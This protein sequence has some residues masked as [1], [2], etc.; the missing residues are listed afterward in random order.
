MSYFFDGATVTGTN[1][2]DIFLMGGAV[3]DNIIHTG[4]GG[5]LVIAD[6]YTVGQ[7]ETGHDSIA[8]AST[9]FDTSTWHQGDNPMV[10]NGN[11]A[12]FAYYGAP[13]TAG[14]QD[15]FAITLSAGELAIFDIDG[16][17][18]NTVITL[19][20][21]AGVELAA[22]TNAP[23]ALGGLGSLVTSDSYLEFTAA[24]AGTY[25]LRVGEFGLNPT[26]EV[27]DE[28]L[29]FVSANMHVG[30][31][32]IASGDDIIYDDRGGD[33]IY[34]MGGDD[35]IFGDVAAFGGE[36]N[37]TFSVY[38]KPNTSDRFAGN[39]DGGNG[40]DTLDLTISDHTGKY[41]FDMNLNTYSTTTNNG[42]DMISI[43]IIHG[44]DVALNEF[45][46]NSAGNFFSAGSSFN[47]IDG[48][49]GIDTASYQFVS[50][51]VTID[52]NIT[53][54][55]HI[56]GPSNNRIVNFE[57]LEG[58]QFG[59]TITGD[60]GNNVLRGLGGDD[61]INGGAG[62]DIIAGGTGADDLD[63]GAGFD[64]LDFRGAA[65][66]VAFNIDTGGTVG[67]AAGDSYSNFEVIYG[68]SFNDSIT[69]SNANEFLY[70]E[71][72]NDT[73]NG[74]GGIDR[75]YGGEGNDVQRG[76]AGND[77]LYGSAGNDQ[78]NG[79]TGFDVANYTQATSAV[80]VNMVSGG[81]L[82]DAAGD[83]YF[84]IEAVYGSDFNDTLTGNNSVNELRGGDGDDSLNGAGGNDRLFGGEGA[85]MLDGGTGIDTVNFTTA[86]S[87]VHLDLATGGT[88]GE[89]AGDSYANIE[90]VFGS[91]FDDMIT[92]DDGNNRLEGRGGD[93]MLDGGL[94]NDRLQGGDGNDTIMGGEGVDTIFGQDGDDIMSGGAGNDF[95]FAGAGADSHDG[96]A[97][98]D[99]VSYVPSSSGVTVNMDTGGTGGDAAGDSYVS[100]ERIFGSGFDDS[101]TGSMGDDQLFGNGGNDYLAGG[102]GDDVLIGGAGS[103]SFGY[104]TSSDGADVISAFSTATEV[105]FI[106][107]GDPDYDSFAE[108]MAVATD[109]G[110]NVIFD[111]GGG[112]SLT[113][114]GQ[115][116]ANLS[117]D[118]FDFSGSPAA[119][120]PPPAEMSSLSL[121]FDGV[122]QSYDAAQDMTA[123]Y[124]DDAIALM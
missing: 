25:Y 89:A 86:Q 74:G 106:L 17:T 63:G 88:L 107:G 37:D 92:G 27:G 33:T 76:D 38:A 6:F 115:S 72:G 81:T 110:S 54:F 1:N 16:A 40:I 8:T 13:T 119:G 97:D 2:K 117:A 65:S 5:D 100:I 116:I 109:A 55:Q 84:G 118:D 112:N 51:G 56:G 82:G 32:I 23:L 66:R 14:Q 45:I 21:A 31:D 80:S 77:V 10:A 20:D 30:Q 87:A 108:V 93:D 12:N 105:I 19:F 44:G 52:M 79:G 24:T 96:G 29:L 3:A 99:T 62:V 57:N 9:I 60:G 22:N 26:L 78:L 18:F 94:G 101:L 68:S 7:D 67:E 85:D 73:I 122:M 70:G 43:E 47:D 111:F 41:I 123:F 113:I 46:G 114:V 15:Y 75:I 120:T 124:Y 4:W 42:R 39:I 61:V 53:A 35:Q 50:F 48:G 102:G 69:G 95:F 64:T 34:G 98:I 83:T 91:A 36:G 58:S 103:D 121:S 90:W 28:Y 104:N 49:A 11:V 71:A 59:D